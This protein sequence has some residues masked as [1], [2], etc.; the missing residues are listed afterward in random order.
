MNSHDILA[1]DFAYLETFTNRTKTAW[2]SFFCNENQPTYFDANHAHIDRANGNPQQI[3]DEVV[4]FYQSRNL[5]PRIYLYDLV[6][7]KDLI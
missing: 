7:Q 1:L 3:I 6:A 5:I 4:H 2:G